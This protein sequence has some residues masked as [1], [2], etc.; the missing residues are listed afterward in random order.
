V[1]RL[2]LANTTCGTWC[3][4]SLSKFNQPHACARGLRPGSVWVVSATLAHARTNAIN[5]VSAILRWSFYLRD[6]VVL[7]FAFVSSD[8]TLDS[9]RG[10]ALGAGGCCC[11]WFCRRRAVDD[12]ITQS[13]D[14]TRRLVTNKRSARSASR[15]WDG[16]A[17]VLSFDPWDGTNWYPARWRGEEN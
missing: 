4:G 6:A 13:H 5:R 10:L 3:G 2:I 15:L 16:D 12:D 11:G 7:R 17:A 9:H 1:V 14:A 8:S